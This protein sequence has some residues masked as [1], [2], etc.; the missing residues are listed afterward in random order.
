[1]TLCTVAAL[2]TIVLV[3][4]QIVLP[5]KALYHYG[6]Y[7]VA[8]AGMAVIVVVAARAPLRSARTRA[9]RAGI[10]AIVFG[11]AI[12]AVAG[13][14]SGLFG[15]ENQQVIGS[16]AQR[17]SVEGLG[18]L[19]F[20]L[21][22]ATAG[23]DAGV[24]LLRPLHAP[25]EISTRS[26]NLGNFVARSIVRTVVE[27]DA[28]DAF[29]NRL[30]ITQPSGRSFLS[31]VLLMEHR[32]TIAGFALPFDSFNLP[33]AHRIVKAVLFSAAEAAMLQRGTE[34]PAVLFAV[35]DENDRP[36]SHGIGLAASG[37]RIRLGGLQLRAVVGAFPAVE[38]VSAPNLVAAIAG[39]LLV[40][41]STTFI[42]LQRR[43]ARYG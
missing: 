11:S 35:D 39:A 31:P 38:L 42:A 37:R 19:V 25:L 17:V 7:N 6:W 16:P 4:A 30:T 5:G 22:V 21:G 24:Q 28:Q 33:A 27:I 29:G 34:A 15:P 41:C 36:L 14:A 12:A 10:A 9:L 13:I 20:P 40:V 18:T 23:D 26:G 3:G 8:I 2:A 32:Q 43:R 1:M